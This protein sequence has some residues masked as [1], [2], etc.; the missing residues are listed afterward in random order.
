[1]YKWDRDRRHYPQEWDSIWL[2]R[3]PEGKPACTYL[4]GKWR[5]IRWPG[6]ARVRRGIRYRI[7]Y[8]RMRRMRG[9]RIELLRLRIRERVTPGPEG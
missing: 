3:P 2:R 9:F 1:M 8:N 7:R 5:T 4:L 6:F